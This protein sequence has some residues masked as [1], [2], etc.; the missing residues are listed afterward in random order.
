MS[1]TAAGLECQSLH[2]KAHLVVIKDAQ[3]Q[4]AVATGLFTFTKSQ[5]TFLVLFIVSPIT[6]QTRAAKN[7]DFDEKFFG[8]KF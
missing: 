7:L 1:W 2:S 8:F 3:E 5:F 4:L 6:R